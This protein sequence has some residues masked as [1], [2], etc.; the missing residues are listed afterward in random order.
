M[1]AQ[2]ARLRILAL[3]RLSI[4]SGR[5]CDSR[6]GFDLGLKSR[7]LMIG[8]SAKSVVTISH[9]SLLEAAQQF[10]DGSQHLAIAALA[11]RPCLVRDALIRAFRSLV[12][13]PVLGRH[14][15]C[16]AHTRAS[17]R[18]HASHRFPPVKS[19]LQ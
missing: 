17:F 4:S 2:R 5:G 12:R 8:K 7:T 10:E 14:T 1:L 9:S 18:I 6:R 11:K 15:S 3:G 19:P 16:K 13:P